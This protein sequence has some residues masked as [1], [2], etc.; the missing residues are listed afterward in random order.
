MKIK[1]IDILAN[2]YFD[3]KNGNSYFNADITLNYGTDK[4]VNIHLPMQYGYG[5]SYVY[6][7]FRALNELNYIKTDDAHWNYCKAKKIIL[8]NAIIEGFKESHL[9]NQDKQALKNL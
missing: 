6:A 3:K 9:I 8:R 4:Q 7:A 5:D 1:T 2:E